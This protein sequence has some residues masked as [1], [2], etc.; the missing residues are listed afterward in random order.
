[1]VSLL[2]ALPFALIASRFLL[3]LLPDFQAVMNR[4]GEDGGL[5]MFIRAA[6][7]AAA[8]LP[9]TVLLGAVFPLNVQLCTGAGASTRR[10]IGTA[11]AINTLSSIA[12][13]AIGGLLIIPL[14][15]TDILLVAMAGLAAFAAATWMPWLPRLR[16]RMA[17]LVSAL[18]AIALLAT[19]KGI[20][21][22][23]MIA[24]AGYDDRS[25]AGKAPTFHFLKEGRAGVIS[26]TSYDGKQMLLQNN[27]LNEAGFT[28]GDPGDVPVIEVLLGLVPY[29]LHTDPQSALV[30]GLGAGNTASVLADTE[31][32]RIRIVEL[33]P[34]V[35]AAVRAVA[36]SPVTVL[37]DA[38][39]E[40]TY[41][42]ARNTLAVEDESYDLIVSQPSHPWVAGTA[43]VFTREFWEIA[44]R[45]LNDGGLFAQWLNLF[46]MNETTLRAVLKSFFE[47]FPE[48][49]VL[50]SERSLILVGSNG[51]IILDEPRARKCLHALPCRRDWVRM[52]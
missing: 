51:T 3:S 40:I 33:E 43:G 46:R 9:P 10:D 6:T 25:R 27:G 7:I 52:A 37:D 22:R 30:I 49:F 34:A 28:P 13:A 2:A 23:S 20:D 26:L 11:Y 14:W 19:A 24:N 36:G 8:L 17:I 47:V 4:A 16:S 50:S 39:V 35:T 29:I 18:A 5:Q 41:N 31:L 48:G 45:R 12:G 15:G 38:R 42:D 44:S 1:M 32:A 21:Y